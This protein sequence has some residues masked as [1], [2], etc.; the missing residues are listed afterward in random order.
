MRIKEA[1]RIDLD[2]SP[3]SLEVCLGKNIDKYAQKTIEVSATFSTYARFI[4]AV[5]S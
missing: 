1:L 3:S 5:R 2:K 4:T